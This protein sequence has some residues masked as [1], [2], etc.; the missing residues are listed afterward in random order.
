MGPVERSGTQRAMEGN[1]A[2]LVVDASCCVQ[3]EKIGPPKSNRQNVIIH[4]RHLQYSSVAFAGNG[5]D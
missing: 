4:L 5:F 2:Y 1:L 3:G